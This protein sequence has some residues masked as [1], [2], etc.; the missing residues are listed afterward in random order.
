MKMLV[1][2]KMNLG[3]FKIILGLFS[4][5][6]LFSCSNHNTSKYPPKVELA[7]TL[8]DNNRTELEKVLEHYS[9]INPDSLKYAAALF[10]IENMPYHFSY[11]DTLSI[12]E[13]Y[14]EI[15]S[16]SDDE[17]RKAQYRSLR[18]KYESIRLKTK[19]DLLCITGEYLINNIEQ[20]FEVWQTAK[21][22][23]HVSFEDFCEYIL[24]YKVTEYQ[25]L[26]N[27]REDFSDYGSDSLHYLDYCDLYTQSAHKACDAVMA[28]I[29]T[30]ITPFIDQVGGLPLKRIKTLFHV[31][32]GSCEDYCHLGIA[33]MRARGIPCAMDYTPQWP[34]RNLGHSWCSLLNNFGKHTIFDITGDKVGYPHKEDHKFAKIFRKT[35]CANEELL[36]IHQYDK[37]VPKEFKNIC[38]KDVTDEYV[39]TIDIKITLRNHKDARYAYLAVFNDVKWVPVYWGEIKN[40]KAE[41]LKMGKDVVYLPV[42]YDADGMYAVGDPIKVNSKGDILILTP[43]Q[44]SKQKLELKRKYP[45]LRLPFNNIMRIIGGKIQ[46]ADNIEFKE[47]ETFYTINK[48]SAKMEEV[49]INPNNHYYRYWRYLAPDNSFGNIAELAFFSKDSVIPLTGK[50]IGTKYSWN[51]EP[52]RTR[53]TVFDNDPLTF[54]NTSNANG[55]WVGMDFG[56]KTDISKVRYLARGDGNNIEI[57]NKYELFYW[58]NG[59]KSLGIQTAISGTLVYPD[60]PGNCL[61]LLKNHTHGEDERIFTYENGKQI[62]W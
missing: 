7:L 56:V 31:P 62:W 1:S 11:S 3:V 34:F 23:Q 22:A 37:N 28:K 16:I 4:G 46:G 49:N 54:L 20:S 47:C 2:N 30:D 27:W 53:E 33:I 52:N 45:Y 44:M 40:G 51:N 13:F 61:F 10:L 25:L 50:I 57:G 21:W 59:W 58:D 15:E 5:I 12:A 26:D 43:E 29:K 9:I 8:A 24:P 38:F 18:S 32:Y 55:A 6:L 36:Q 17:T 42:C 39:S 35:Y 19:S 41:F 48:T 60:C 14:N